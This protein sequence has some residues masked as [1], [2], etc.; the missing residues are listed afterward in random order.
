[1]FTFL[2]LGASTINMAE[3][4]G[5]LCLATFSHCASIGVLVANK[6][7]KYFVLT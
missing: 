7:G 2:F 5:L 6:C 4:G 3:R 1:M